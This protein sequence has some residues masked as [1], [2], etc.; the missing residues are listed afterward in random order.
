MAMSFHFHPL[1]ASRV[2][3]SPLPFAAAA[4]APSP[5]SSVA[6][7]AHHQHGRRR[8]SAIVATAAAASAA[9]TEFDFKAYMGERAVAVN[10]ALDA[11]VPAGEPPAALHDAMRYALLAGGKRVRPA[12]CLAACAVV[13]G[14]EPWAMPA[15]AAV[16]MVHT[17]SLVHDDLPCMDDDDLRRGKPTCHVVY[18]EPIAVLAGD[19]LLSLSFHHMASVG[20]YPP[21]VDPEKH[22]ARVVRAI[23]ELARC[24]GSEGLVAGQ[25][26]DLE[27]TGTSETVPLERLEYIHLHKTAALLEASVVIGAI[28]GG[29]T[30]E[31]IER[32]RKYARSIGLLFQV[33]DDI[34]DVTKSS[35]ELG[36]TAGKDLAS[37]KTTYPKLLGLEKSRE[38]AEE[39]L[40]DAVEQLACFDKEKAAPLLHLANY[41]AHRQN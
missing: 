28:I 14:P 24:I 34:L 31:Q 29:G 8:F 22:P 23:G 33:V 41:I 19:A 38:F 1:A 3:F 7:A 4:G 15:A 17:M 40:S 11:A 39:L 16:E 20:S 37:D 36:K 30:D 12:L 32:L 6:I 9:T 5:S 18:G 13:G 27:M 25:V 21:D 35:E 26:V 10:R 2:H